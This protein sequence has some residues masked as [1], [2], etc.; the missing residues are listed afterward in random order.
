MK[1]PAVIINRFAS[2]LLGNLRTVDPAV[3]ARIKRDLVPFN[4]RRK[5]WDCPRPARLRRIA[6]ERLTEAQNETT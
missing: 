4:A 6:V 1:L 2:L 3:L 5:R